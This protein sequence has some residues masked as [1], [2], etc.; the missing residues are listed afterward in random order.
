M[1]QN[2]DFGQC[3]WMME[4]QAEMLCDRITM[5]EPEARDGILFADTTEISAWPAPEV[6]WFVLSRETIG[7]SPIVVKL[8]L[9]R[10]LFEA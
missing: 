7:P 10:S 5:E 3:R 2:M 4:R 8:K 1:M 9:L 6:L